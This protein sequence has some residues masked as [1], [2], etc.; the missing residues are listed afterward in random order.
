M[1]EG[2]SERG[3]G[4]GQG[5]GRYEERGRVRISLN[6]LLLR[7]FHAPLRAPSS[8]KPPHPSP[9]NVHTYVHTTL[10]LAP[11]SR[12]RPAPGPSWREQPGGG[13]RGGGLGVR[14][15][16]HVCIG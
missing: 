16:V 8:P 12:N 3:G 9:H 14:V 13:R 7:N 10:H 5:R 6:W 11:P 15:K 2:V 1:C 4:K